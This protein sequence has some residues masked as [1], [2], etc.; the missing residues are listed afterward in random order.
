MNALKDLYK[1]ILKLL[2]GLIILLATVLILV[3]FTNVI[4]RYFFSSAFGWADEVARFLFIWISFIGAVIAN[5]N[6]GHMNLDI[7]IKYTPKQ[8]GYA[9][10]IFANIMVLIISI[11]LTLG[12]IIIVQGTLAWLTPALE[13]PYGMVYS[14][15]PVCCFLLAIQSIMHFV[16]LFKTMTGKRTNEEA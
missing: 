16:R 7:L 13:I 1:V 10:Q 4:A 6:S 9:V 8:V 3:V 14:I 11:L 12:G 2:S 15:A 5:N